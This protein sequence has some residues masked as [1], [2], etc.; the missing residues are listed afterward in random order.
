MATTANL[1]RL[2][3]PLLRG[4]AL[5]HASRLFAYAQHL[6]RPLSSSR[7]DSSA[8]S[9]YLSNLCPIRSATKGEK[10]MTAAKDDQ[11]QTC[12]SDQKPPIA[13]LQ[14]LSEDGEYRK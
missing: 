13:V 12:C 2:R 14:R 11:F 1:A 8:A 3:A 10:W 7:L 5:L 9:E 6:D 4:K